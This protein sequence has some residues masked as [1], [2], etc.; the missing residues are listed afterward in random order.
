MHKLQ[1]TCRTCFY[2]EDAQTTCVFRNVL[3]T[4]AGE[5]AGVTQDVGSDPTVSSAFDSAHVPAVCLM[6][7]HVVAC[8]TCGGPVD[9]DLP[10]TLKGARDQPVS[11]EEQTKRMRKDKEEAEENIAN[12][13][14]IDEL[15]AAS[16]SPLGWDEH[17]R[18]MMDLD[19]DDPDYDF[20]LSDTS[21]LFSR[22]TEMTLDL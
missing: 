17:C 3:N 4:S 19:E 21:S 22:N 15:L 12:A 8:E 20:L 1:F 14:T 18:E 5:T 9:M 10:S 11:V 7:G 16:S 2:T 13:R 6:C